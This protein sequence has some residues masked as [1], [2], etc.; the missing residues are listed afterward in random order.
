VSKEIAQTKDILRYPV[1][2]MAGLRLDS[3]DRQ[4]T[5]MHSFVQTIVL[6]KRA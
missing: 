2:S 3:G 1:K 4:R 6:A 5:A